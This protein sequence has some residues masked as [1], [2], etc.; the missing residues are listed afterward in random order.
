MIQHGWI[1]DP[2]L[3]PVLLRI[4]RESCSNEQDG[5]RRLVMRTGVVV[6]VESVCGGVIH[7]L[8]KI[9]QKI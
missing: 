2:F 9:I 6:Q 4:L 1:R 3:S 5:R 7:L 8:C